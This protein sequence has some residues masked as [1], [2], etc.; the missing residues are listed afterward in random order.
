MKELYY[1]CT[2]SYGASTKDWTPITFASEMLFNRRNARP[3]FFIILSLLRGCWGEL[4]LRKMLL[5]Y[6]LLSQRLFTWRVARSICL[7]ILKTFIMK[8]FSWRAKYFITWLLV[9]TLPLIPLYTLPCK[10]LCNRRAARS[11]G[12]WESSEGGMYKGIEEKSY[13]NRRFKYRNF[14]CI[15]DWALQLKNSIIEIIPFMGV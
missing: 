7:I 8:L 4:Y 2:S 13:P 1:E 10:R 15:K 11:Y 6:T 12:C 5:L 9:Y 3:C 14:F